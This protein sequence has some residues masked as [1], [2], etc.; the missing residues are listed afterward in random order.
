M[1]NSNCKLFETLPEPVQAILLSFDESEKRYLEIERIAK[2]LQVYGYECD[3]D[4]NGDITQTEKINRVRFVVI[5]IIDTIKQGSEIELNK[6][7]SGQLSDNKQKIY[8]TD[9]VGVEWVFF[10]GL[11]CKIL[12]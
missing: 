10:I 4:M 7:F 2:E 11:T 6:E 8:Y 12:I 9:K 1:E 5:K 3:Y